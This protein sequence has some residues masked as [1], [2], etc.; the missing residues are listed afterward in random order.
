MTKDICMQNSELVII[1]YLLERF[2][3]FAVYLVEASLCNVT[4][5]TGPCAFVHKFIILHLVHCISQADR[6]KPTYCIAANFSTNWE[7]YSPHKIPPDEALHA[8]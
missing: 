7:G 5:R 1:V 3:R 8:K 2:C 6:A 4:R